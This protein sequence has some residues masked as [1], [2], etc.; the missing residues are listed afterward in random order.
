MP[1][2]REQTQLT[3]ARVRDEYLRSGAVPGE[4]I[5]HVQAEVAQRGRII[6]ADQARELL[7]D[8]ID[9]WAEVFLRE[10]DN[11]DA[12]RTERGD[13]KAQKVAAMRRRAADLAR[14]R[15]ERAAHVPK[16]MIT[17]E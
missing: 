1:T 3:A 2:L 4:L 14:E 11:R 7:G 9:A 17:K 10:T 8:Y 16:V 12:A 6:S 15:A 5:R 13:T